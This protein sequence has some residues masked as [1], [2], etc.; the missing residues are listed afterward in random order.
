MSKY[1]L[2]YNLST[3]DIKTLVCVHQS[4]TKILLSLDVKND[5]RCR[6]LLSEKIKQATNVDPSTRH[7]PKP[8]GMISEEQLRAHAETATS[9]GQILTRAGYTQ[10]GSNVTRVSKLLSQHNIKLQPAPNKWSD[11]QVYREHSE[12]QRNGLSA[13]VKRDNWLPYKCAHCDNDGSWNGSELTLHLDHIDGDSTNNTKTNL[14]WLCPNC[15]AQTPT[16]G[17]RN[18]RKNGSAH[19]NRTSLNRD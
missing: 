10:H 1:Q 12:F 16:W 19:W 7:R 9:I 6:K 3:D 11:E 14:R 8:D 18:N 5:P 2:I 4:I 13:R 15:H 17:G